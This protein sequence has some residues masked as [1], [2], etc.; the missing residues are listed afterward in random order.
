M[1][2]SGEMY[3]MFIPF[4]KTRWRQRDRSRI[5]F[6]PM[7]ARHTPQLSTTRRG[8]FQCVMS[9]ERK[10]QP[11]HSALACHNR[12]DVMTRTLLENG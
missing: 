4:K 11:I 1:V 10:T 6:G 9:Q 5:T 2:I 8:G 3:Q 7:H 12:I